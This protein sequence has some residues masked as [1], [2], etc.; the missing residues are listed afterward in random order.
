LESFENLEISTDKI[1][2]WSY[3]LCGLKVQGY[4]PGAYSG[5]C[6]GGGLKFF[7]FLGGLSTRWGIKTP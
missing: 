2:W 6:P 1:H 5:I 4:P 3:F 7:S